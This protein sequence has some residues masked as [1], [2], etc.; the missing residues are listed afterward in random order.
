[1][2]NL[3]YHIL[4]GLWYVLSLLPLRVHYLFSDLLF[5][6][7]FYVLQYRR[8]IVW[9]NVVTSFPERDG[10]EHKK[11]ERA[12]YHWFCDYIAE[13]VKLLT[14]SEKE[15]RR[16]MV[17]KGS[18]Q[19]NQCVAEGQSCA[20][21]LGH[22]CNWEWIT[23]LPFWVTPDAHCGQIY[24]PLESSVFDR[25]FLRLRQ[26]QGAVCIAMDEILRQTVE[27]K[28]KGEQTVI[29]YISDQ[30]P[31]WRDIDH[32]CDFLHHDTPVLTGT[33]RIA[34]KFNQAV[35]YMDVKRVKRGYYEAEFKLLTR[36]PAEASEYELTDR[37]FKMLESTIQSA[38]E[39][40]LW[41]HNRWKRT[42]ERFN[43][44][45]YVENG[46]VIERSRRK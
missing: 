11:I 24:H 34:R 26:R 19:V 3:L 16:R 38:P 28:R 15:L 32:W 39:F 23:S 44:R 12:F 33:E 41:T 1:M 10:D 21:Y 9:L 31:F 14:M 22:Y 45:F 8:R 25:L 43:L 7:V 18:E 42:R 5:F 4:Y 40:W 35:F 37:Y 6:F 30:V 36:N 29:G 13:T 20:V 27:Y 2:N 46:K 17:F